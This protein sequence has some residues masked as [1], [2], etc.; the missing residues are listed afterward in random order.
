M[1]VLV[2]SVTESCQSWWLG[3]FNRW[4]SLSLSDSL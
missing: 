1:F 2:I 4:L 3:H